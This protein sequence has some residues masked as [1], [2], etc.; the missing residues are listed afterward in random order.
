MK[1]RLETIELEITRNEER[2]KFTRERIKPLMAEL[3]M[4]QGTSEDTEKIDDLKKKLFEL[5]KEYAKVR[6]D[7]YFLNAELME[8]RKRAQ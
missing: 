3:K 4:L 8:E 2:R 5:D 7:F 6:A 1:N